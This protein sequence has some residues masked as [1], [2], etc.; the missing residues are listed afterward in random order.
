[1]TQN[2]WKIE[3]NGKKSGNIF[4]TRGRFSRWIIEFIEPW[5][6]SE[7]S[8]WQRRKTKI[9][10]TSRWWSL[11]SSLP[12]LRYIVSL[13]TEHIA[14]LSYCYS[15]YKLI[16]DFRCLV[17]NNMYI[18]EIF[19]LEIR[20]KIFYYNPKFSDEIE[21]RALLDQTC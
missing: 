11:V 2:K 13:R 5:R 14:T 12:A 21:K 18:C 10:F 4:L 8:R 20:I 15:V 9:V 17:F 19:K 1:M 3:S 6:T 7:D 16:F